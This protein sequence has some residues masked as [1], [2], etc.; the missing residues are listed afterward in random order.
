MGKKLLG[1][2]AKGSAQAQGV[3]SSP[4]VCKAIFPDIFAVSKGRFSKSPIS[5]VRSTAA[6][7]LAL[8]EPV[9]ASFH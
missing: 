9:L 7:A 3:T 8:N 2:G 6:R 5:R 1:R 4:D